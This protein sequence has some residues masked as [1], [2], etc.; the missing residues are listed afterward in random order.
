[1]IPPRPATKDT[2]QPPE[3]QHGRGDKQRANDSP[4]LQ[5]TRC[6]RGPVPATGGR[7]S[8]PVFDTVELDRSSARV[9]L[10]RHPRRR[11]YSKARRH[12]HEDAEETRCTART[13]SGG[14]H[15]TPSDQERETRHKGGVPE[16]RRRG[17]EGAAPEPLRLRGDC[18]A[19]RP[20]GQQTGT[21][22]EGLLESQEGVVSRERE[23]DRE[24]REPPAWGPGAK[25]F[26]G[27]PEKL[28]TDIRSDDL[29]GG[30]DATRPSPSAADAPT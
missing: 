30:K 23:D 3:Q 21:P 24:A 1:M 17:V 12:L 19:D 5:G 28:R 11:D 29:G 8:E 7:S 20:G 9:E 26:E 14:S 13:A 16:R 27:R 25:S 4:I 15:G 6:R 10:T 2:G 22:A 18:G